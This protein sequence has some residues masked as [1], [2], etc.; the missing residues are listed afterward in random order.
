MIRC[1]CP[2]KCSFPHCVCQKL[3]EEEGCGLTRSK[4]DITGGYDNNR[5]MSKLVSGLVANV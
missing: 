2:D 3:T 4:S 1:E 5:L